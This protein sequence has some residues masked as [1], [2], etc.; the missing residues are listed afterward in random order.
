MTARQ[1]RCNR[2][3]AGFSLIEALVA[4]ALMGMILAALATVIAQ[5]L[6]NWNRGLVQLQRNEQ[7]A[8]GVERMIADLAAAEFIPASRDTLRPLF[9]GAMRSVTFV[10]IGAGPAAGPGLEIV[11]LA[12]VS[13]GREPML[14]RTRAV[15][16]PVSPGSLRRNEPNFSDPVVLLRGPYRLSFSY[17][18]KDR[19]WRDTWR[20]QFEL[21]RAI[22]L[23]LRDAA[24]QKTLFVST[25]TT[26]HAEGS[27][28]CIAATSFAECLGI[29]RPRTEPAEEKSRS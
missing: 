11:R 15:F 21:P 16:A 2:S 17:A 14:L 20:Q 9:D 3:S 10:R 18:G 12:E 26:V 29:Q 1:R 24:T 8:L 28:E 19:I 13:D 7:I 27:V 4:M 22:K 23:S 25:A 6:P 5:W